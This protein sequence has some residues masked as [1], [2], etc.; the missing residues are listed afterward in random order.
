MSLEFAENL[1]RQLGLAHALLLGV[2]RDAEQRHHALLDGVD[3]SFSL[4]SGPIDVER[5][6]DWTWSSQLPTHAT[7]DGDVVTVR[8]VASNARPLLFKRDQ[9]ERKPEGF[10]S[11]IIS[12]RIEPPI[13]VVDH[14]VGCFRSHRHVA[15]AARLNDIDTLKTF[16]R[17]IAQEIRGVH[18]LDA[19]PHDLLIDTKDSLPA[20]HEERL[21]EE[22]RFS[23]RAGRHAELGL[24]MRHVAGMVFQEAHADLLT[25]PLQPQL[26]GLA[27]VPDR[28]NRTQLGAYY[29]PPGLARN[30]A[31]LAIA[32]HLHKPRIKIVDPACGSGIFLCEVLRALERRG[33]Q[34]E[35]ELIGFDVSASA[36]IMAKFALDY[37]GFAERPGV[38][39]AVQVADFLRLANR[40]DADVILMNPPFL[41]LPEMDVDVRE[42]LQQ[43]LGDAFRY[44]PDLS[45]AFTSLAQ[46]HLRPGGTLATLLPAGALSQ[47]GGVKWR[48]G[49]LRGNEVEL[50]A[51]LGEHGLF[52]DAIVNIAA[53][54]LRKQD[55]AAEAAPTM[56]WASQ[57][58]GA[59]SAA[60]RRLRRWMMGDRNAE[61]T[62][63][64]S[65][66][67]T[68][69][70][71]LAERDNWTP[72]PYSLGELPERLS[73]TPGVATVHDLFHV[74]LGVRAGKVGSALQLDGQ[75][76][77]RLPTKE[78]RLF[79]PVAETRSIRHGRIQ[80]ITWIFY[81][82]AVMTSAQIQ[83]AAPTFHARHLAQLGLA[84]DARVDL[85]RARR[86]TNLARRPRLVAR[87]FIGPES[88]AVDG[89]GSFVVVQ[90]YSWIPKQPVLGAPF[91]T[92][93]LLQD[94]AF[95]TNSRLFF[96]LLRENGRIVGGGQVDGAKNQVR[97]VPLP[98]LGAMYL[99][100]PELLN[101]ARE[102]R[103]IDQSEHPS[104]QLLDAFT[105]AAYRTSL[106]EWSL[107]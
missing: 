60:L 38:T 57:K 12:K 43:I 73:R 22:L 27:P 26:F 30:L 11:A 107:P 1:S 35:V 2:E 47:T 33:Y 88:F 76:Y 45:M 16:L 48:D 6:L 5:V 64:W 102:L 18:E 49:L 50:I 8:Q 71:M 15:A 37:G 94:Y 63:D 91:D 21:R 95:L 80:P 53:L 98:D 70:R 75:E 103:E 24:T 104:A 59:S 82:D 68:S 28:A 72:R 62:I 67:P 86:D 105:A 23:R 81:P 52:R 74:E 84:D 69:Q 32:D 92:T 90:G 42:R 87:A 97:R 66:Y 19:V 14:L 9:V 58:R 79:R 93:E 13:D 78:R 4:S 25:E 100:T 41:A 65:I 96:A 101:Q 77:E 29:T 44:R 46:H 3:G 61:R 20:D 10:L 89:D 36:I 34:G 51:V 56:L 55:H 83:R 7:I 54:V 99:E 85:E 31:D 39:V 106:D 17:V 40:I